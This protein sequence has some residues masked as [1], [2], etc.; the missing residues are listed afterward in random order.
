MG[1]IVLNF[2]IM[3][4]SI[5][6]LC[7]DTSGLYSHTGASISTNDIIREL[8]DIT[9]LQCLH[10]C[11]VNPLCKDIAVVEN[12]GICFLLKDESGGGKTMQAKRISQVNI[13]INEA[14]GS[15]DKNVTKSP[16]K[17]D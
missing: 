16:G 11:R 8:R 1:E 10:Q 6:I 2:R 5:A 4:S 9:H 12:D 15:S 3:L 14:S 13:Q 7:V 17:N